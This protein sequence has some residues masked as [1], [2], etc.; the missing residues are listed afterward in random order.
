MLRKSRKQ[1]QPVPGNQGSNLANFVFALTMLTVG[2]LGVAAAFPPGAS[3]VGASKGS[4]ALYLASEKLGELKSQPMSSPALQEGTYSDKV[5]QYS[6][7][8]TV[9][10]DTPTHGMKQI[11]VI[12]EWNSPQGT[13]QVDLTTYVTGWGGTPDATLDYWKQQQHGI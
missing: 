1:Q 10:A 4:A 12:V 13:R 3:T 7:R 6:R 11:H 8:W 9:T 2:L 5:E